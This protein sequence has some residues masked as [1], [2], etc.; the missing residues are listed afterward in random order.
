MNAPLSTLD[1]V[2][3]DALVP[4]PAADVL[5]RTYGNEAVAWSPMAPAPAHL[6]PVTHLVWQLL[7]GDATIGEI[8]EDVHDVLGIPTTVARRQLRRSMTTLEQ[9]RLVGTPIGV[10]TPPAERDFFSHPL[11]P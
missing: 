2:S 9:A 4:V 3:F 5:V 6:D 1:E 7:D 8:V 11:N 10:P